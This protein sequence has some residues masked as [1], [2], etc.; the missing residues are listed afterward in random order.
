[1]RPVRLWATAALLAAHVVVYALAVPPPLSPVEDTASRRQAGIM[2][3]AATSCFRVCTAQ[4]H[5]MTM[6]SC[7]VWRLSDV[8]ID[9]VKQTLAAKKLVVRAN[10]SP[11]CRL[12]TAVCVHADCCVCA[13][14][15]AQGRSGGQIQAI[16]ERH[17]HVGHFLPEGI[18]RGRSLRMRQCHPGRNLRPDLGTHK[19]A[20]RPRAQNA[21]IH[22]G[23][24]C[25]GVSMLR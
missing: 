20:V 2:Q 16:Y 6:W 23:C 4:G 18:K 5:L 21:D 14:R 22:I 24:V 9:V 8:N 13:D 1:M 25:G 10:D 12:E 19:G 7:V 11:S 3:C 15:E 17:Q